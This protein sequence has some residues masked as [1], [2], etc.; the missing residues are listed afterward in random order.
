MK[1]Q[2]TLR[3][4]DRLVLEVSTASPRKNHMP[5]FKL[6]YFQEVME[7][8]ERKSQWYMTPRRTPLSY[9]SL[10]NSGPLTRKILDTP[11]KRRQNKSLVYNSILEG[12][13]QLNTLT[14]FT[15]PWH[16]RCIPTK[17]DVFSS[18]PPSLA[19]L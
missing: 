9:S 3:Y 4:S 18:P 19:E 16:I 1:V 14:F 17:N 12:R 5:L 8:Y 15:P 6:S 10:R 2:R 13:T 11:F 7:T